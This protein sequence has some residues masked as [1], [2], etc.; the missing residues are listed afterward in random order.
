MDN[1]AP[2]RLRT[3]VDVVVES[4]DH[5][6]DGESLAGRAYLSR[7]HFDRL[8]RTGPWGAT[9]RFPASAAPRAGGVDHQPRRVRHRRRVRRRPRVDGGVHARVQPRVRRTAEPFRQPHP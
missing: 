3:L 4:L 7:F 5:R 8:L 6:L 1:L 9:R 2:D